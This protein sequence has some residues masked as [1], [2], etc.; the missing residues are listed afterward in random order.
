MGVWVVAL[1]VMTALVINL[2]VML[3]VYL[4]LQIRVRE[5]CYLVVQALEPTIKYESGNRYQCKLQCIRLRKR[6]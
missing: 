5:Y 1:I 3:L 6:E 4:K 2:A